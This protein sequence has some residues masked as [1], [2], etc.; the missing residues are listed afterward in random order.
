MDF[1]KTFHL[2]KS[3]NNDNKWSSNFS[4]NR[5]RERV[6]SEFYLYSPKALEIN[7]KVFINFLTAKWNNNQIET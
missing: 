4:I 5:E 7:L 2:G 3:N 6:L 1:L